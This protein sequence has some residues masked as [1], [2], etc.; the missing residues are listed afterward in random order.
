MSKNI[1]V[2]KYKK[3]C[4]EKYNKIV[5]KF[6]VLKIQKKNCVKNFCVNKYFK[7][8][9]KIVLKILV[10]KMKKICVKNF[11]VHKYLKKYKKIVLKIQENR[12]KYF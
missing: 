12:F 2:L 5:L 9:K 6:L 1:I 10:L 4:V 8:Y 11:G 3:Y 7:K